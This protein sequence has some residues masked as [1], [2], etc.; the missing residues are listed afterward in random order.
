MERLCRIGISDS[1]VWRHHKEVTV[2]LETKL[3]EEEQEVPYYVAWEDVAAMEWV[4]SH[5][6]IEGHAS[7]SID[8]VKIL[9]RDEGYREVKIVSV[10]EVIVEPA[11]QEQSSS[12]A[13]ADTGCEEQC[14]GSPEEEMR[15]RQDGL[16]LTAHSYRA[17]L[18][19]KGTF[20]SA[21]KGEL[22]RRRVSQADKISTVNDGA[23]WIGD[24]VGKYL[25]SN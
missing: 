23:D 6:V 16:K 5:E 10:S 9:T 17:V 24:L 22:A 15:G 18:G 12:E 8:G 20:V 4:P 11:E 3:E 14:S 13:K 21:L 19:D 2:Q 1:T 7:V 25:P